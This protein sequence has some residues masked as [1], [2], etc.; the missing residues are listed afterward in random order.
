[1]LVEVGS[2]LRAAKKETLGWR[3]QVLKHQFDRVNIVALSKKA[4]SKDKFP[5][6]P[7][8]SVTSVHKEYSLTRTPKLHMSILKSQLAPRMT[9]GAR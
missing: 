7:L 9:S 3:T 4:F 8:M 2:L 5:D 6:L 1:M